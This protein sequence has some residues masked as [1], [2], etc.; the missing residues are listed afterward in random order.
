MDKTTR[1]EHGDPFDGRRTVIGDEEG[2]PIYLSST[3]SPLR[4]MTGDFESM[5]L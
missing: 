4:T 5:A 3:D 2:R 1:G